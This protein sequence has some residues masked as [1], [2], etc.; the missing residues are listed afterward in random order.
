MSEMQNQ[1]KRDGAFHGRGVVLLLAFVSV[2]VLLEPACANAQSPMA[3]KVQ[4]TTVQSYSGSAALQK[5]QRI[6]V[7]DFPVNPD[8]VQVD[9]SQ[10]IRLR[11]I[12][13]GDQNASA[14]AKKTQ[15]TYSKELMAKL[16]KTGI[17]VEHAE[18]GAQ[19]PPNSLIVRGS[20]AS[21][22]Q[23]DKTERVALGFGTGTAD[24]QTRLSVHLKTSGEP[25]LVSEFTTDTD[26]AKS[27]GSVVPVVAGM[28][29]AGIAVKS[30]VG[31]RRKDLNSYASK[32]ADAAA[33]EITKAIGQQGWIKVNDKGEV[34]R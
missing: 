14:I 13:A 7:Y 18:A 20:F 8:D 33:K 12:I 23:G 25:V 6:V 19:P 26:P 2:A 17:P 30:T 27:V 5:P 9:R 22:K 4:V 21:L 16:A 32:S 15:N 24:I 11:R 3:A 28:N 10:S 1:M 34:T 29:P 31:D